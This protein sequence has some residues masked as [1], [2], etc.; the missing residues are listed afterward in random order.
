[1]VSRQ[2][3]RGEWIRGAA[4]AALIAAVAPATAVAA[5]VGGAPS[6]RRIELTLPLRA[7]LSGLEAYAASITTPGSPRYGDYQPIAALARRFGA[8][9]AQRARAVTYLRRHGATDVGV[10]VTGLFADAT[11][12]VAQA[13]TMFGTSLARYRTGTEAPFLAPTAA[14]H[15][16]APLRGA[17]TG[18]IG[19]DTRP[20]PAMVPARARPAVT[21]L[22][23]SPFNSAYMRRTGTAQGCAGGASGSGFTPNQ[24][25][26]AYGYGPLRAANVAGQGERL[27]LIEIDGFQASD[28][29]T[30]AACFGLRAPPIN[31]YL[32]GLRRPLAPGLEAT[33]DLET[34]DAA[35]PGLNSIDVYESAALDADVLR[36]LTSPLRHPA[37]SPNV[38]S[39]S[40]GDCERFTSEALGGSGLRAA[41]GAL[42][43]E[44]ADGITVL[45]SS[46]DDGSADCISDSGKPL[47]ALAVNFPASS[48]WIT[49]V[50]GTNFHLDS[51]NQITSQ[52]VW[53][54]QPAQVGAGGGGVSRLFARPAYQRGIWPGPQ[55]AV[56]DIAALADP[57]PGLEV[58]CSARRACVTPRFPDP[59]FPIGGT[60]AASPLVA[61]GIALVDQALAAAGRRPVGLLN[62]LIY[63]L[64]ADPE[65]LYD[66]TANGNDIG[67]S[68]TGNPLGCC[69][70]G[71]GFDLASGLGSIKLAPFATAAAGILPAGGSV[72]P[73]PVLQGSR[74][75]VDETG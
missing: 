71:P 66:V 22:P 25:L 30:F 39:V 17:V 26:T 24:Y 57:Q 38:I 49:S 44:A 31:L 43:M 42:A 47:P 48:P 69:S 72:P 41:E 37:Q 52:V 5:R 4:I 10:D 46:G 40:L 67:L 23:T 29:G 3:G 32:R 7:D 20:L 28:V 34:V 19:L 33:L 60:S 65:V 35:A 45:A 70:A 75:R 18:V 64:H 11:M 73:S 59:W 8:S 36:S 61:G 53:N 21:V 58:F 63:K 6:A 2:M 74:P 1:M 62:A 9:P 51:S 68:I 12:T 27:A 14:V 13:Q 54:D 56:P 55:R 15:V 50:G 16:P